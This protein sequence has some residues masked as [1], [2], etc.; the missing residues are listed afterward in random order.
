MRGTGAVNLGLSRW[1]SAE[2]MMRVVNGALDSYYG[3]SRDAG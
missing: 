2:S 1:S 3:I